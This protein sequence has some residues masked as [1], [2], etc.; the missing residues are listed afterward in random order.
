[1]ILVDTHL[2]VFSWKLLL[3]LY[4]ATKQTKK[5]KINNYKLNR[6]EVIKNTRQKKLHKSIKFFILTYLIEKKKMLNID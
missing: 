5:I 1:M 3:I 2:G 6:K 4:C